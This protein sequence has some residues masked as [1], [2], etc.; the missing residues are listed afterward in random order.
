MD[1]GNEK[2]EM[3]NTA[4]AEL[5]SAF[6]QPIVLK[7][8]TSAGTSGPDGYRAPD[9]YTSIPTTAVVDDIGVEAVKQSGGVYAVGDLKFRMRIR[10][11]EAR[12]N[13]YYGGDLITY[14]SID[15]WLVTKP[16]TEY[17]GGKV[18]WTCAAR[19]KTDA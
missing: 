9:N 13:P 6:A 18:F 10:P 15:Y 3:F 8:W 4:Q 5:D 2:N 19:R 1:M 14:E 17:L 12:T 16:M 7:R 11:Q